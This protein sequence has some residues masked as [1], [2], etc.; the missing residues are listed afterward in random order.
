MLKLFKRKKKDMPRIV[1][2]SNVIQY[3]EM[4]SV[5]KF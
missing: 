5:A 2:R 1:K 4:G 3:D